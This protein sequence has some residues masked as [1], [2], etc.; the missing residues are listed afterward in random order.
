MEL[1]DK[2]LDQ[3]ATALTTTFRE[4]VQ[5]QGLNGKEVCEVFRQIAANCGLEGELKQ[6]KPELPTAPP[7]GET[8][9]ARSNRKEDGP[10]FISRVYA[11]WLTGEF[12]RADLNKIDPQAVS[13]L[14]NW[15]SKHGR[16]T[17]INLPTVKERNDRL[18]AEKSLDPSDIRLAMRLK[19]AAYRR[20]NKILK[21]M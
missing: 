14:I 10:A 1:N 19:T 5:S 9:A 15:E 6:K 4:A 16:R 18:L 8:Y 21:R 11:P 20:G 12:T 13:A 7:N 17:E 3:L 2:T